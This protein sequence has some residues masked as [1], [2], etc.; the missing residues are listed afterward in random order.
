MR[1][2]LFWNDCIFNKSSLKT[3][4]DVAKAKSLVET[5]KGR[6]RFLQE[7][8]VEESNVNYIFEIYYSSVLEFLH[9]LVLMKGY[10]VK[11]HICLGYYFRDVLKRGD[12]F[13]F[14]NDCR[15]KRNDLIYNGRQMEFEV[16]KEAI[17]RCKK[18]IREL[19]KLI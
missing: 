16:A 2:E 19:S 7:S 6:I 12:I 3:S 17:S 8:K 1:K 15:T 10:K 9:A 11:N 18:L 13:R 4:P 5:A 14:F